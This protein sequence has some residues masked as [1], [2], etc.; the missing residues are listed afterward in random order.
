MATPMTLA[1]IESQFKRWG[2]PYRVIGNPNT[3]RRDPGHGHWGG[4]NGIGIHHTGDDA[5][6][7]SDRSLISRGRSDLPGPLAQFG[8]N[9]DGVIDI[10]S[11]GRSNHFGTGDTAVFNAVVNESYGDYPPKTHKHDGSPGGT[12]GNTHFYGFENYYSGGHSMT[13]K[14]YTSLLR[15]CAAI[16]EFY[17]WSAKSMIGH[18]EWSDWKPDPGHVDMKIMRREL[19]ALLNE[20]PNHN[21]TVPKAP[22]KIKP[23]PAPVKKPAAKKAPG[24]EGKDFIVHLLPGNKNESPDAVKADMALVLK[25]TQGNSAIVFNT[26]RESEAQRTAVSSGLGKAFTR[27]LGNENTIAYGSNWDIS[28]A[29][30]ALLLAKRDPS[31]AKVSPRR[32]LDT[33]P[34]EN[35]YLKGVVVAMK[36]THLLSEANCKHTKVYGRA[37]REKMWPVQVNDVLDDVERDHRAGI[38]VV[39]AGDFNTGIH[40]TGNQL[41]A[42]LKKRFGNYA[43]HVHNGGL[44]HIFLISSPHLHLYEQGVETTTN[45]RSDHDMVTAHL[46]I[47][48]H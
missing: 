45:N 14:Q 44:D 28:R 32:Y 34:L 21:K 16:C 29:P 38:P 11:V 37:W 4:V 24:R 40:F 10:H 25:K 39:L 23:K 15:A 27:V 30:D 12:D 8:G 35:K 17:K 13:D 2:V 19:Q 18:K 1:Q 7:S 3:H 48:K 42:L 22:S 9:D 20:G 47:E 43:A 36:G 26:E 41:F 33:A 6:D 31:K 46:R 5:P